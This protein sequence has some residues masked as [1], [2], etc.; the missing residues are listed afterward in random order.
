MKNT[1]STQISPS[2][3]M[4]ESTIIDKNDNK[5]DIN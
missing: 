3:Y 4:P 1:S 5:K 2:K